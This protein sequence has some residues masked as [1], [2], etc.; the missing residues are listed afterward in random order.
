[1]SK[2]YMT[3]MSM[4]KCDG[5]KVPLALPI[6][7][8][9]SHG[10]ISCKTHLPILNANDHVPI[11]NIPIFG[12]CNKIPPPPPPAPGAPCVPTTVMAWKKGDM[13][14]MVGGAPALTKDSFLTC[15]FGGTIK[16]Q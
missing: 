11:M 13:H 12:L 9:V 15:M 7:C 10:V 8:P 5:A 16:F 14:C 6:Q 1:M 2:E 3:A 4:I